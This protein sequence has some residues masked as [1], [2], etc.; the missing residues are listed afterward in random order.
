MVSLVL[1]S[2]SLQLAESLADLI[3]HIVKEDVNIALAAGVDDPEH[4]WG[5]DVIKIQQ[6]IESVYSDNGV[7]VL[8]DL[9]SA[10]LSAEMALEFLNREQQTRVKLCAAPLV[11]GAIAVAVIA[12][13][14][15]DL[16]TVITEAQQSLMP[17]LS[18]LESSNITPQVKSSSQLLTKPLTCIL[19]LKNA[20]G[21]HLR[22]A[23]QLVT[24]AN[25]FSSD[26]QVKNITKSS[27]FV[28]G[29]SL[30]Q[31]ML[32]G[33]RAGDEIEI[34]VKGDDAPLV[35]QEIKKL[36]ANNFG[37]SESLTSQ[38]LNSQ[39]EKTTAKKNELRGTPASPGIVIAPVVDYQQ[40]LPEVRIKTSE[41]A[42]SEWQ[43]LQLSLQN[44][45]QKI[46]SLTTKK[47][48][49]F[50][51][52]LLYLDDPQLHTQVKQLIFE[53]QQTASYAWKTI[54]EQAIADYQ[55]LED[56]Y[57]QARAI[58]LL[59][60]GSRV[61]KILLGIGT[62]PLNLETPSILIAPQLTP[63]EV[64]QFDSQQVLGICTAFGS[65]TDHS[66]IVASLLGIPM[67]VGIGAELLELAPHTL[68]KIDGTK[69][70]I[71]LNPSLETSIPKPTP[72]SPT[73]KPITRDGHKIGIVANVIG[74]GDAQNAIANGAQGVGLLR[75]E[76]LYLDRVTPPTATEQLNLI[77]EI[78]AIM[79]ER[80]L[81]IRTL[82]IGADK[83]VDY[84]NLPVETNPG[85][86]WRGIRQSLDCP[87]LLK[88]QLR[89]ILRAS[90]QHKIKLMFPM[91]TSVTEVKA[92]KQLVLEVQAELTESKIDF[93][94]GIA[95]GIMV[96]TPAAVIMAELLAKEVDFFSIGTNDLGQYIMAADRTNPK[97]AAL[98]DAYE[99]AVLRMI[100]QTVDA[101]HNAGITVSLCGQ[102]A[103]DPQAVPILLGLGVDE[104]S[105]NP[106]AIPEI[107][108]KIGS[109]SRL[110]VQA[111]AHT[112]LQL[113]SAVAVREYV[114]R[115][116]IQ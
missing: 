81:T 79:G 28:N 116:P 104:L 64:V 68:V 15:A 17:K 88:T 111:I 32:L 51:S 53:Q 54:I 18:H 93:D 3:Q 70:I 4:P 86:G 97:V 8:M 42:E 63:S 85:L 102:L 24:I 19:T 33:V 37:E 39:P 103:S 69:G 20:L 115:T 40:N 71:T 44:A 22:P 74:V 91:V 41:N 55:N 95:I 76:F 90:G 13:T 82:D 25:Q 21:L 92:A 43:K 9:G 96:E 52:H 112:G 31:L 36:I 87:E 29:K 61:L 73:I 38:K 35:F 113:D 106:S 110:A 89:A 108:A 75:T 2:H 101:A 98:A 46:E 105:V 83:P 62:I 60:I 16:E 100:R 65:A 23:A 57:L 72:P 14:G 94:P 66:A 80:P 34:E 77:E 99:P 59:D 30:N 1:V 49:I 7:V 45:R 50:Q 12:A 11:E 56:E 78:G 47:N 27:N 114:S 26:I 5:T 58:D 67:V 6:A 107:N 109:L 48:P 10:V 84:L